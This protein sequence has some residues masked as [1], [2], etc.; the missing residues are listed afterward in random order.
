MPLYKVFG[1]NIQTKNILSLPSRATTR[2]SN[3]S[4]DH[5]VCVSNLKINQADIQR[6]A[7]KD[8]K[9]HPF[10]FRRHFSLS[11]LG[12]DKAFSRGR[13]AW[14]VTVLG[15]TRRSHVS[16]RLRVLS[17]ASSRTPLWHKSERLAN[18]SAVPRKGG[19]GSPPLSPHQTKKR[20]RNWQSPTRVF[21]DS[22]LWAGRPPRSCKMFLNYVS[23]EAPDLILFV[24]S[25]LLFF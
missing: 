25:C 19:R 16:K 17:A 20:W 23:S 5:C 6:A 8:R 7:G 14:G 24:F 11:V 1:T 13:D 21:A 12:S 9:T 10:H 3:V 15:Q 4:W 22:A 2:W 18:G